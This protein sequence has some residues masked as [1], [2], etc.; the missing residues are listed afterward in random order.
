ME[1]QEVEARAVEVS[2]GAGIEAEAK[3]AEE[4]GI[5]AEMAEEASEVVKV[6]AVA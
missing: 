4:A 5:E 2:E 1:A 6:R 3:S